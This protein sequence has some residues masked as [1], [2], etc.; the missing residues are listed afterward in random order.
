MKYLARRQNSEVPTAPV[1]GKKE[2][3]FFSQKITN[4]LREK[5]SLSA[6]STFTEMKNRW[7][8]IATGSNSIMKK[9]EEHLISYYKG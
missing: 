9:D 8:N 5:L 1:K 7:N 2:K 4:L 6:M 3:N